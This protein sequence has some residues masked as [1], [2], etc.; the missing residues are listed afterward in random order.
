MIRM[1][2]AATTPLLP[3][4]SPVQKEAPAA[5]STFS[6]LLNDKR[7]ASGLKAAPGTRG[8]VRAAPASGEERDEKA[9]PAAEETREDSLLVFLNQVHD[10]QPAEERASKETPQE[11]QMPDSSPPAGS[12]QPLLASP[13]ITPQDEGTL[14]DRVAATGAGDAASDLRSATR[15]ALSLTSVKAE[16]TAD[17]ANAPG[18]THDK[19]PLTLFS[20]AHDATEPALSS[21]PATMSSQPVKATEA[22]SPVARTET[23]PEPTLSPVGLSQPASIAVSEPVASGQLVQEMGTPAWQQSLGQQLACFTRNGIQHAEL[24]LHPEELGAIHITLQLRNEQA[25]IHFVS[26]SH[27]VRAAIE[28]TVPH[29]RTSLAESGIELGQSSVS[30][31]SSS[32]W[33]DSSQSQQPARQNFAPAHHSDNHPEPEERSETVVRTVSYSSGINTFV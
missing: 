25:Q 9:S 17:P 14:P 4:N 5:V 10:S 30:A 12:V 1:M 2:P 15:T 16:T 7:A 13:D 8:Q 33:N 26:A 28:A 3:G 11:E 19:E 24:R 23:L 32:G 27:Q 21:L 6:Q 29:L 18:G 31:D 22:S 20:M